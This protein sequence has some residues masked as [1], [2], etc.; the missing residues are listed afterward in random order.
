MNPAAWCRAQKRTL[1][2]QLKVV[3]HDADRWHALAQAELA[4]GNFRR[5]FPLFEWRLADLTVAATG[6]APAEPRWRGEPT[7]DGTLYVQPEQGLG[8][9]V[10]MARYLPLLQRRWAQVVCEVRPPLYRLF[11]ENFGPMIIPLRAAPIEYDY[12]VPMLSLPYCCGTTEEAAIPGSPYLLA[13]ETWDGLAHRVGVC[14]AGAAHH[15]D[16]A[17]RSLPRELVQLFVKQH[18]WVPW[19]SLQL[20][21]LPVLGIPSIQGLV[22]DVADTANVVRGLDLVITCDT[23]VAHLAGA[24]GV[25][26]WVLLPYIADW[27]W[28]FSRRDSPWYG[29][30]Q[31]F[32]QP[33]KG[34]WISVLDQ[35]GWQLD[36]LYPRPALLTAVQG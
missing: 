14:W 4:L 25:P 15:R 1:E 28:Q 5:G 13:P 16:D 8:D 30:M 9:Q 22:K 35:V 36:K 10:M 34:D 3:P 33:A 24:L 23:L 32:R 26:C 27:R 18:A 17:G 20:D 11:R 12:A 21:Q 2:Q 7:K 29:K 31:L 6:W 19:L